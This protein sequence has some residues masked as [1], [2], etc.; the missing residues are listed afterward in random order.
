MWEKVRNLHVFWFVSKVMIREKY[1][2]VILH[3]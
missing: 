1:R 2:D 3:S